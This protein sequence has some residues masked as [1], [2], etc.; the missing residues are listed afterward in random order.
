MITAV[1]RQT[2]EIERCRVD[3][4]DELRT[5]ATRLF[6]PKMTRCPWC[7][8][9]DIGFRIRLA[10]TRQG[11]P[12]VFSMDE[13]R[14]CGHVFQNP[15][16][17]GTGLSYYC[18]DFYDGLGRDYYDS[19][20]RY[21]W[22]DYRARVRLV[23]SRVLPKSWLDVCARHGHFCREARRM[24]PDTRFWA[25]DPSPEIVR[26]QRRGWVDAAAQASLAE[27]A[28]A[29]HSGFDVVSMV[30]YLERAADSRRELA[31]AR[32]ILRQ[33]GLVLI[34]MVNPESPF[35]RVHG[36]FWYC[37]LAPQNVHLIPWRNMCQAIDECGFEVIEVQLGKANKPFDN[38]GA[39]LT[40]LNYY[41]PP[42][43]RWP[44]IQ[45]QVRARDKVF[46]KAVLTLC[47]P[48]MAVA[49][50]VDVLFH[51][52]ISRGGSGNSYRIVAAAR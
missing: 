16:L 22:R 13:C 10:D 1:A 9:P 50:A 19:V 17:T 32:R 27:F 36:K 42:A 47:L 44:W 7:G 35:A 29:G 38:V 21:G 8:S 37:W 26:A 31:A 3:Y 41:L 23:A 14:G 51:V 52:V 2:E 6:H 4:D 30:N 25:I 33:G 18:R 39:I 34:E 28:D 24:L 43:T 49:F 5:G 45:R 12:G 48:L 40:A 46:R 20:A 11:K 15:R